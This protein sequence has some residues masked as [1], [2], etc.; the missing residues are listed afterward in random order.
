MPATGDDTFNNQAHEQQVNEQPVVEQQTN[1]QPVVNHRE[2][3]QQQQHQYPKKNR[4]PRFNIDL[5]GA[6]PGEG[7]LEMM[8]DGY[9]FCAVLIIIILPA[10][11]I[12]MFHH[13]K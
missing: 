12:F 4:E 1:E 7:V 9:G 8:P 11:M 6:V 5:D 2:E 13:H 10:L 3:T